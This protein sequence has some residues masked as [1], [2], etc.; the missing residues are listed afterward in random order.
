LEAFKRE[1]K[2]YQQEVVEKFTR[3]ARMEGSLQFCSKGNED[4]YKSNSHL[5]S[6]F[7]LINFF[8]IMLQ[9]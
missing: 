4:Q 9:F 7:C 2:D 5:C 3:K 8:R 6:T 1:L